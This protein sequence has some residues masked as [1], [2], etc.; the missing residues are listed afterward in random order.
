MG[1]EGTMAAE[2]GVGVGMGI[3]VGVAVGEITN[4][5]TSTGV[6]LLVVVPSPN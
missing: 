6:E 4:P 1:L 3:V 5:T 2:V